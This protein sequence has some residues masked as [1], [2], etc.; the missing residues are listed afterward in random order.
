MRDIE[1]R[2]YGVTDIPPFSVILIALSIIA[3]LLVNKKYFIPCLLIPIFLIA[4]SQRIVIAGFDFNA[5]RILIFAG[6]IRLIIKNEFS[7][8]KF[9]AIDYTVVVFTFLSMVAYTIQRGDFSAW[10]DLS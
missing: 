4:E 5:L 6:W 9:N 1:W 10:I 3:I 7:I 2:T 8:S